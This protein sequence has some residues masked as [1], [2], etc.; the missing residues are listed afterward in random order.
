MH[1]EA[2]SAGCLTD[3]LNQMAFPNAAL[4]DEDEVLMA[5]HEVASSERLDL[6]SADGGVK[7]PP[8]LGERLE[9]AEASVLDA[10]LEAAFTLQAGL[11]GEKAM[12]EVEVRQAG[13]LSML[14]SGVKLLGRHGD[15]QSR[16]SR[17]W[18]WSRRSAWSLV[19]S[20]GAG[21]FL[22]MGFHISSSGKSKC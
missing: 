11:V 13:V 2:D 4:A 18:I 15:A 14:E 19:S 5:R 21:G 7:V 22:R 6:D 3:T 12:K 16:R 1:F 10:S 17:Q 9:I 20:A 8:E